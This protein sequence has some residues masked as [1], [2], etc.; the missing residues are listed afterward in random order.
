MRNRLAD[1]ILVREVALCGKSTVKPVSEP[2]VPLG[3]V[4]AEEEEF[5]VLCKLL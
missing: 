3:I 2:R 1:L 4:T 5:C